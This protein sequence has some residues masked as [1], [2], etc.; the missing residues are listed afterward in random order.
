MEGINR[1]DKHVS[2]RNDWLNENAAIMGPIGYRVFG[3]S[4]RPVNEQDIGEELVGP[5]M[6][7]LPAQH[8]TSLT[9]RQYTQ[10]CIILPKAQ[11]FFAP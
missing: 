5:G 2:G 8:D 1:L 4:I 10:H 3:I 11:C 9:V 6:R 7:H